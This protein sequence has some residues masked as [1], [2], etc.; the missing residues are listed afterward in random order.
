MHTREK[1]QGYV[2][3][4]IRADAKFGTIHFLSLRSQESFE[5]SKLQARRDLGNVI[6]AYQPELPESGSIAS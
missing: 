4:E 5:S 3:F 2:L 6:S 1:I